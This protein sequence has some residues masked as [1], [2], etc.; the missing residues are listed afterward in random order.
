M[1][2]LYFLPANFDVNG[3]SENNDEWFNS[4]DRQKT[5]KVKPFP[6]FNVIIK[7]KAG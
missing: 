5:N 1:N 3:I 4:V 6:Y 2:F 7:V